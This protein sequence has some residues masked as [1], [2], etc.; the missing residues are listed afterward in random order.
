MVVH[1]NLS[2]HADQQKQQRHSPAVTALKKL[3]LAAEED[4]AGEGSPAKLEEEE[5]KHA[6]LLP[7]PSLPPSHGPTASSSSIENDRS[8]A[9]LLAPCS[10]A[11]N[12]GPPP[13]SPA[14]ALSELAADKWCERNCPAL[15]EACCNRDL[16]K[17]KA[18]LEQCVQREVGHQRLV[19]YRDDFRESPL[20]A[21]A[22]IGDADLVRLLLARGADVNAENNL[23][24]TP[25]N[26]AAIAG[27]AEVGLFWVMHEL[28]YQYAYHTTSTT[29]T[30]VLQFIL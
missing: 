6:L 28:C 23:G 16:P 2:E 9:S 10:D 3:S 14:S 30:A 22:G 25:L 21:A 4:G 29:H 27:R 19:S 18:I 17:A 5:H 7:S 13:P 12:D 15:L 26:R 8:A 24:S 11:D 1:P 20:T